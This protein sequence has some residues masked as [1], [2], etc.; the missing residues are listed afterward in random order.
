MYISFTIKKKSKHCQI[1][2]NG[3]CTYETSKKNLHQKQKCTKEIYTTSKPTYMYTH[4]PKHVWMPDN[5]C[6]HKIIIL[7]IWDS[8]NPTPTTI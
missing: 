1:K 6:H 8:N 3:V 5:E 2:P 4:I 7:I